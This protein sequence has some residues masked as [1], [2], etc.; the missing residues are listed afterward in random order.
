MPGGAPH[1]S[2]TGSPAPQD[3]TVLTLA[4]DS[5]TLVPGWAAALAAVAFAG[6]LVVLLL[7]LAE[8]RRMSSTWTRFLSSAEE[9]SRP[10]VE[11]A[12]AAARNLEHIT[13]VARADID[14]VNKAFTGLA[15]G[16]AD[17][18]G[19][20]Q[21]RLKDLVALLDLAQAEAEDA[22]LEGASRLRSLRAGLGNLPWPLSSSARAPDAEERP[23]AEVAKGDGSPEGDQ[24]GEPDGTPERALPSEE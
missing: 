6:V 15:G 4:S 11:H 24:A 14:R 19:E 21:N 1:M 12:N 7:L 20:L 13:E 9:R 23:P 10:L 2:F 5:L 16:I 22:I 18:S 17:A 8:M 3:T